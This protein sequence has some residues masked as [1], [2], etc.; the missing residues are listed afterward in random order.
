[1]L[2]IVLSRRDIRE[3][4]QLITFYSRD[5]GKIEVLA[6]GIK[7]ILSKN[8]ASL[9][10]GNVVEAE[11]IAGKENYILGGVE[12]W[13][14]FNEHRHNLQSRLFLQWSLS[15]ASVFCAKELPDA[16]MFKLLYR[17]LKFLNRVASPTILVADH[18]A[19]RVLELSGFDPNHDQKIINHKSLYNFA[20]YHAEKHLG[21]WGNMLI[22][23]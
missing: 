23:H 3:F 2:A 18:F 5:Q 19:R 6:R 14:S 8:S 22:I 21:D 11:I 20:I 16:M 9:A 15:F 1:M 17:W 12:L 13:Q 10:P 7:K 4:D